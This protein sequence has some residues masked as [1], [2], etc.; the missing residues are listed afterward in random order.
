M[1][2]DPAFQKIVYAAHTISKVN[3]YKKYIN[4][5]LYDT[6]IEDEQM[7]MTFRVN[8]Q[9]GIKLDALVEFLSTYQQLA[10]LIAPDEEIEIRINLQ[11]PGP[12]ELV[13]YVLT[14]GS[15][16]AI[17]WRNTNIPSM[18]K[19]K[20]KTTLVDTLK[21]GGKASDSKDGVSIE[22]PNRIAEENKQKNS[23][24]E[25]KMKEEKHKQEMISLGLQNAEKALELVEKFGSNFSEMDAVFPEEF[26]KVMLK[27][28]SEA[29]EREDKD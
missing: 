15:A 26:S 17:I 9:N 10:K 1:E 12:I 4:R 28:H 23:E 29:S 20:V 7:H 2:A 18:I 13:G 6:Y 8:K 21:Y 22:L 11:S 16:A 19:G 5:A 24:R 27:E 3:E 25:L 14:L